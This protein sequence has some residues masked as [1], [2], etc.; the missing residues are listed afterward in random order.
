LVK[1]WFLVVH[2]VVPVF[3]KNA[4]VVFA[5]RACSDESCA[6][7]IK[8]VVIPLKPY[9]T[10]ASAVIKEVPGKGGAGVGDL[11]GFVCGDHRCGEI[12]MV[13]CWWGCVLG[14]CREKKEEN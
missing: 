3:P 2:G 5:D 9:R 10:G 4:A 11:C 1:V 8:R 13:G 6:F 14:C 7:G 12:L